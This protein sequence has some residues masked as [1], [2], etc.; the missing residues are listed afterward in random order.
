MRILV[1]PQHLA[2]GGSHLNAVDLASAV[3]QHGH[4]VLVYAPDGVLAER[5]EAAGLTWIPTF[6]GEGLRPNTIARMGNLV[7]RHSIDLVHAYEWAPSMEAAFGAALWRNTPVLMSVMAMQV[8]EFLP[9]HLPIT[10]GTPALA[11]GEKK[12]RRSVHLLEPPVDMEYNRSTDVAAARRRWSAQSDEIVISLVSMLTTELE[13]LQGI[14]AVIAVT[15]QLA[16]HHSLRLL[17]AGDGE[18]YE[19]VV[20]RANRVNARHHRMVIQV[21]GF[22]KDPSQVYEAG[23]IVIG[24]GSSAIKGLAFGKPLII[25]GAAGYWK[26]LTPDCAPQFIHSGWFGDGGRG[27]RDLKEALLDVLASPG[28]RR[29]LG[30]FSRRLVQDRYSLDRAGYLLASIYGETS[31]QHMTR[32]AA[33]PSLTRSAVEVIRF[34]RTMQARNAV[35]KEHWS[36]AGIPL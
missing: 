11:E 2:M 33:L 22:Q 15:D 34:Q 7:K 6:R 10:V 14:L 8:P 23:D 25:Q 20:G 30:T 13:K 32:G 9:T 35:H 31:Q 36:R 17:I 28:R 19:Q 16:Q 3:G 4:D 26:L 18:G 27:A 1:C 21:L 5:V 12:R 29:D 24:M